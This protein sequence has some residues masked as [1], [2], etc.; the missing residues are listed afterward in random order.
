M[1]RWWTWL[2]PDLFV[3]LH[4]FEV[5]LARAETRLDEPMPPPAPTRRLDCGHHDRGW[6]TSSDGLT[7]CLACHQRQFVQ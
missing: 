1:T 6:A 7:M 2:F 5:R 4:D 3:R